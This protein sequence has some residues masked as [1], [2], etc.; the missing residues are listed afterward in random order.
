MGRKRSHYQGKLFEAEITK[1]LKLCEKELPEPLFWRRFYDTKDYVAVNKYIQVPH[2]PCDYWAVYRGIPYF[3]EAKSSKGTSY[4]MNYVKKDQLADLLSL[5]A[6]GSR[7]Y[8]VICYRVPRSNRVFALT[9]SSF[10]ELKMEMERIERKSIPWADIQR[11]G[12]EL[13]C[14]AGKV[15]DMKPI[16]VID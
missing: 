2:Q 12:I 16:F 10:G 3:I 13:R 1:S 9:A 4:R 8:I 6:C 7:C 11:E 5:E 15:W 14:L